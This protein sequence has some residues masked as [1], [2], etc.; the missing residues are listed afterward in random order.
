MSRTDP[1]ESRKTVV[2]VGAREAADT[3]NTLAGTSEGGNA[4]GWN[5]KNIN[6][7]LFK[8]EGGIKILQTEH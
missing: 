3:K 1:A 6:M 5:E 8:H 4:A 2:V 7:Y